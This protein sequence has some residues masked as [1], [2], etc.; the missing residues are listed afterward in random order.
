MVQRNAMKAWKG[1]RSFLALL[2]A[3]K[4]VTGLLP[5][6]DLEPLFDEQYYLRFV[7]DIFQ[8]IGLTELQWKND[9]TERI[10]LAPRSIK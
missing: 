8:R 10:N 6:K 2:K 7:D 5:E 3:D 1:N 4:E 9:K